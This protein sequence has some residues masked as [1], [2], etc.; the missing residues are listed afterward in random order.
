MQI[1]L[2][3]HPM[4]KN[5][6]EKRIDPRFMTSPLKSNWTDEPV[7]L[8]LDIQAHTEVSRVDAISGETFSASTSSV[9]TPKKGPKPPKQNADQFFAELMWNKFQ[10]SLTNEN[11]PVEPATLSPDDSMDLN[12]MLYQSRFRR[13]VKG[14]RS[15]TLLKQIGT[16]YLHHIHNNAHYTRLV[17]R[18]IT[19][20]LVLKNGFV[21]I[22]IRW[23]VLEG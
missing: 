8:I 19:Q 16:H 14:F 21:Y 7:V 23:N 12:R 11:K 2:D 4:C 17:D 5:D 9:G 6:G 15:V 1:A 22:Y 18:H 10:M 13:A 3:D 20:C